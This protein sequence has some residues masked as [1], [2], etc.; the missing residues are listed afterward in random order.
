MVA[1]IRL[2]ESDQEKYGIK[3]EDKVEHLFNLI[4]DLVLSTQKLLRN[5]YIEDDRG[6]YYQC[7]LHIIPGVDA[8]LALVELSEI[9]IDNLLNI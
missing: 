6:R 7:Q 4:L 2:E 8:F 3:S 1:G 9:A 5:E